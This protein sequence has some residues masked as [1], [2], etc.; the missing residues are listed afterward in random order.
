[1]VPSH[2][3][4]WHICYFYIPFLV[5][6][7]F[8]R[9]YLFRQNFSSS[10]SLS[11]WKPSLPPTPP[12]FSGNSGKLFRMGLIRGNLC[13]LNTYHVFVILRVI[14]SH[15]ISG[16]CLQSSVSLQD[17]LNVVSSLSDNLSSLSLCMWKGKKL[18]ALEASPWAQE[19]TPNTICKGDSL[20]WLMFLW[21]FIE[22]A[23]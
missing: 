17:T 23:V 13:L 10:W 22:T 3:T 2:R 11:D 4:A 18:V 19:C 21:S 8:L 5:T 1:M 7:N 6:C 14:L 9:V 20:I 16:W 15:V 12:K